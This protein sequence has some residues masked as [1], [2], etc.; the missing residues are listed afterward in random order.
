MVAKARAGEL[1][2]KRTV[3]ALRRA[4]EPERYAS[5]GRESDRGDGRGA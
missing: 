1:H 3:W 5:R 2:L 4:I